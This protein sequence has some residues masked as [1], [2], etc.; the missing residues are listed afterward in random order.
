[1]RNIGVAIIGTGF[2]GT[3]HAEALKRVGVTLTGIVGSSAER[4]EAAAGRL[5]LPKAYAT[6]AEAL[7][8][9]AVHAVH[10]CTP[11]RLHLPQAVAAL[12]AGKHVLCEKPLGMDAVE[13]EELVS[14]ARAHPHLATGVNYNNRYYA[15]VHEAKDR[16]A[17]GEVGPLFHI[18]G[19]VAQDWLLYANDYN[20]RVLAEQQGRLRALADIGSH[21]LDLIH[22]ISGLEIEALC[23]DYMTI[24]PIR[25]R[26]V[27]EVETFADRRAEEQDTEPISVTTD[28]F[29]CVLLRF[30]GGAK[31]V[32]WV[33]Q[34]SPGRKYRV[35]FEIAG[36]NCTLA[37]NSEA[38]EEMWVGRRDAPNTLLMRDPA[39]LSPSGRQFSDYPG[40][41]A[42]GYPDSFKM[43]FRSFY[44]YI[45]AAAFDAPRTYPTFEDG[46]RD[47]L[48]CEAF[49]ES[50]R[51]GGWVS[52][53]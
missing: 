43:C 51:L 37:W 2:M 41:H 6:Y 50:R 16:V 7:R 20:W 47:N 9:P 24:H 49:L 32:F 52:V 1:M 28:D 17:R 38:C 40:G 44:A 25:Y 18:T 39:L 12:E 4:S 26:P 29:G 45:A 53:C 10:L 23:A 22:F 30:R 19:S 13:S 36:Q 11:N 15:L 31:G 27:G 48:L 8:D 21:W 34:V 35:S 5:G 3:V 46:H 14:A 42:E 33:S